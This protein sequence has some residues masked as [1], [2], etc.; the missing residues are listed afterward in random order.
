MRDEAVALVLAAMDQATAS[1][2]RVAWL[3]VWLDALDATPEEI[4][5]QAQALVPVL[6]TGSSEVVERLGPPLVAGVDD[7][8]LA[9]VVIAALVV[10]TKKARLAVL[11]A[12]AARPRPSQAT[13]ERVG[14]R[15]IAVGPRP[16]QTLARVSVRV[17]ERWG[18]AP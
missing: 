15:A 10:P 8:L 5:A 7:D 14:R 1:T 2:E 16:D 9:E 18:L 13:I 3:R 4:V 17:L 11:R 12:L 6:A